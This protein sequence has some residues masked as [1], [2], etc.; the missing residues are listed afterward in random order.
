MVSFVLIAGFATFYKV[1]PP[2]HLLWILLAAL[3]VMKIATIYIH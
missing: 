1:N 3:Q 2:I